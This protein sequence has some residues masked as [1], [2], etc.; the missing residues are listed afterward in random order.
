[1]NEKSQAKKV[2]TKFCRKHCERG[3]RTAEKHK[4]TKAMEK[5]RKQLQT[6]PWL[7]RGERKLNTPSQS[8]PNVSDD[9]L[10]ILPSVSLKPRAGI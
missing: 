3:S 6:C 4:E 5:S 2:E 9:R 1:M 10:A 8:N 7:L